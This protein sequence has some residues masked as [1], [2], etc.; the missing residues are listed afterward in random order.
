MLRRGT[1]LSFGAALRLSTALRLGIALRRGSPRG[2]GVHLGAWSWLRR[3][4]LVTRVGPFGLAE[5]YSM[6]R[7]RPLVRPYVAYRL[8]RRRARAGPRSGREPAMNRPVRPLLALLIERT[9]VV[10]A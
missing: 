5:A 9:V 10:V 2:P 7:L 1:V 8:S 3:A 4:V 6:I